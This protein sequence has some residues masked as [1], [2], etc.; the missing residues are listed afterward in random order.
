MKTYK[1]ICIK[2]H[3]II[4]NNGTFEIRRGKEYITSPKNKKNMVTVYT[5][6]WADV[7]ISCFAGA[8]KFT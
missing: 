7:P 2:N 3:S 1:R 6:F 4:G 5:N 8:Q